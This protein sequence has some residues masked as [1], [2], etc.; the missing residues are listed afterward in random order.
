[1]LVR[2]GG[3]G[4]L[5]RACRQAGEGVG[6]EMFNREGWLLMCICT[7]LGVGPWPS[8]SWGGGGGWPYLSGPCV[9]VPVPLG[10]VA[11]V[12]PLFGAH[13]L[14][15]S[16]WE[17]ME[18]FPPFHTFH[19]LF[20]LAP[21][22]PQYLRHTRTPRHVL[23]LTCGGRNP[24]AVCRAVVLAQAPWLLPCPGESVWAIGVG[25]GCWWVWG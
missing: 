3:G 22:C 8:C 7:V 24:T 10:A 20:P 19:M 16:L 1:M 14:R 2:G 23:S 18:Y 12:E 5:A 4:C 15:C 25:G 9:S 17:Q 13:R 11:S 21:G 6:A